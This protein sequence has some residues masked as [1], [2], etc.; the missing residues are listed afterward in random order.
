MSMEGD[1]S[2]PER[3]TKILTFTDHYLPGFKAGGPVRTI[4]GMVGQLPRHLQFWIVTRDRDY[5]D[6]QAYPGVRVNEWT[7][8]GRAKVLY[9]PKRALSTANLVRLFC[10]K[11]PQV[12]YANSLFS[13]VTIRLLFA[14][15]LGLLG[16]TPIVLAPRGEFSP[17]ALRIRRLRKRMFL[18]LSRHAG[19]FRKLLWQAS[20]EAERSDIERALGGK[21]VSEAPRIAIAPD[22]FEDRGS[23]AIPVQS[24]KCRG[25]ARFVFLSRVSPMK[26]LRT[27]I[28]LVGS[29]SGEVSLDIFG[30]VDDKK[31]F[32]ECQAAIKGVRSNVRITW[33]G[34]VAPDEVVGIIAGFDFFILPTFGENFGHV[35]LESLSAS[36]PVLLS[37]RTSWCRLEA[38]GAGWIVPLENRTRWLE[39]LQHCVEMDNLA[40]QAM[41]LRASVAAK[42]CQARESAIIQ[43]VGLFEQA[44]VLGDAP[45]RRP[46]R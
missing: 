13:R 26:N 34:S 11:Q 32:D 28:E 38:D 17:G 19:L 8:V 30:P 37:N 20:S 39:V 9:L 31:Y 22:I 46:Q 3:G 24:G 18:T 23:Y 40:H 25:M 29:L 33:R 42:E 44:V 45:R 10:A 6:R 35:I 43:N 12:I 14:S 21:L 4:S 27:A 16:T 5:A 36:C 1:G 2:I 7:E 41:R 15:R